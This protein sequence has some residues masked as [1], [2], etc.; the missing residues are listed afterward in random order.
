METRW[1]VSRGSSICVAMAGKEHTEISGEARL[2][3]A[4]TRDLR[5]PCE[6]NGCA[7]EKGRQDPRYDDGRLM[8]RA[9]RESVLDWHPS[10]FLQEALA[11]AFVSGQ[12]VA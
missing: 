10:F 5:L 12:H 11:R 2:V 3:G 4:D 6:E 7:E 8:A 9:R 1:V